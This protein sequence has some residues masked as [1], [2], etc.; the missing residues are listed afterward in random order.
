MDIETES[1]ER[2]L[3][4]VREIA[5]IEPIPDADKIELVTVDGW[6]VVAKKGAHKIGD[7]VAYYEID[8]FLPIRQAY[9]F[10]RANSLRKHPITGEAGY[11]IRTMRMRGQISQGLIMPLVEVA[12][13]DGKYD[14]GDDLTKHLGVIKWDIPLTGSVAGNPKGNFPSF[15]RKTDETR[16]QNL[17]REFAEYQSRPGNWV[18]REKL[19]GSSITMYRR[20]GVFGICSR[21]LELMD[22]EVNPAWNCAREVNL[23]ENEALEGF[24]I[25]GELIG[26]G[27]QK[28]PYRLTKHQFRPFSLFDIGCA[29]Y[30]GND[31]MVCFAYKLGFRPLPV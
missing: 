16:I 12:P 17:R 13:E 11:K 7:R 1:G 25:Q 19:D 31:E 21:N 20:D 15:L 22:S 10:L 26:P 23:I 2:K 9:E 6:K 28:N 30:K 5:D 18:F 4:T 8:S 29:A 14:I 24:A 3:V 27:I